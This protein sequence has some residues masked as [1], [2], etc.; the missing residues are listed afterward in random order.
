MLLNEKMLAEKK[1]RG[2][3][4]HLPLGRL[5]LFRKKKKDLIDMKGEDTHK[6]AK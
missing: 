6:S 4:E 2:S 5:L 1:R 3:L